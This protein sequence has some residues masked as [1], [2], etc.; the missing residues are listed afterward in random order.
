MKLRVEKIDCE[1]TPIDTKLAVSI[2]RCD[3]GTIEV[4][5]FRGQEIELA[6][7]AIADGCRYPDDI[8]NPG[9]VFKHNGNSEVSCKEGQFKQV[10]HFRKAGKKLLKFESCDNVAKRSVIINVNVKEDKSDVMLVSMIS[11][12]ILAWFFFFLNYGIGL[13]T[14]VAYLI[15][16]GVMY[17]YRRMKYPQY[18]K[19]MYC[20]SGVDLI[21]FLGSVIQEIS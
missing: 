1:L 8:Y 20:L 10:L 16:M 19:T 6:A 11:G 3:N 12:V 4:E 5:C 21:M 9:F 17:W 18:V 2:R 15:P 13:W 14:F 7:K